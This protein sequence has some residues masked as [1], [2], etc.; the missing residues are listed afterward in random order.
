MRRQAQRLASK[1]LTAL[2][3]IMQGEGQAAVRLA[4]AREILDRAHGRPKLGEP[5]TG[6][7]GLTVIVRQFTDPPEDEAAKAGDAA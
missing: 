3:E 1:A 5:E 6:P 4:A 2:A 7:E